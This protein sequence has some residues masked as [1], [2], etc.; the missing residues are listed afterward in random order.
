MKEKKEMQERKERKEKTEK[1]EKERKREKPRKD[2]GSLLW[3]T[4]GLPL[5]GGWG[6]PI[7]LAFY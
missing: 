6:R 7:Y 5:Y 2:S 3:I 4:C 1:T